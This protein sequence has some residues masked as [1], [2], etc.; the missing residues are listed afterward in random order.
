MCFL[1]WAVPVVGHARPEYRLLSEVRR[2]EHA[3]DGSADGA[4]LAGGDLAATPIVALTMERKV[5][6]S[7]THRA[8]CSGLTMEG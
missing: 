6:F 1:L 3:P 8:K 7:V 5:P 2:D 4:S